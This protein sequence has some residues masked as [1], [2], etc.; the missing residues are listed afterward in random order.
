MDNSLIAK[1]YADAVKNGKIDA[2][3]LT[4]IPQMVN[5]AHW[6]KVEILGYINFLSKSGFQY[7]G[8]LVLYEKGL[9]FITTNTANAIM[10][11]DKRFK[12]VKKTI[13]VI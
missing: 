10:N 5:C 8:I 3:I 11:I 4:K 12:N 7:N 9:Y 13:Q 2:E 6:N 1:K